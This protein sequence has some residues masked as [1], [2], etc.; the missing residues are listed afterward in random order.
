[1]LFRSLIVA[2]DREV[3]SGQVAVRTRTGED[4]G[5]LPLAEFAT[6]LR[7]DVDARR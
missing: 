3:D 4:L 7:E 5:S 2:G 6:R 1:M